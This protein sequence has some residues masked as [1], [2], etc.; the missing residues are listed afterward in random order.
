MMATMPASSAVP[1]V[2]RRLTDDGYVIVTGLLTPDGAQA[3]RAD[4]HRVL[5]TTRT[6]R[7]SFEGFDTQRIYA[8][9]AKTRMFDQL[10]TDALLLGVLDQVLGHYQLSA[11]VGICIGPGEKAQILHRDDSIY[12]VPEPHPPLV[13]NTMWPLDEFTAE[14]GATRFIPGSHRWEPGRRPAA[15][16]PVETAVMSPGSAM[17]YLGSLWH[18]GGANQ[19]AQPRLG[20]ILEYAAGW[21]RPQENHCLAVP[22]DVAR[23]LPE[24]LQELLGYNIY[25][26]FVGYVDGRHPRKVLAPDS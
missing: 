17:F 21:L 13:V 8:L 3:A 11:P 15:G 12:P 26:P 25:P 18:G 5:Q 14:N 7:N 24:R 16:D 10:A 1:D 2:A 9:F 19:T 20:V 6:G 22:R 23:E 4:L